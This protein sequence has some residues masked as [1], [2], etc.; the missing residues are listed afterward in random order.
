VP[1]V[2]PWKGL[3][4][5]ELLRALPKLGPMPI[6]GLVRRARRLADLSQRQMARIA[7]VSAATVGRIEA[8]DITPSVAVLQ[9]LLAAGGLELVAVDGQGR[10]VLPMGEIDDTRDGT[11]RRYP[12]H[13]DTIL[14]PKEGEWWADGY[15]LA[16]PPETFCRDRRRR[17]MARERSRQELQAARAARYRPLPQPPRVRVAEAYAFHEEDLVVEEWDED[18]EKWQREEAAADLG[19]EG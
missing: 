1:Q 11:G 13:L 3:G 5:E 16:R 7:H 18:F 9:R 10:R 8:G 14:D 12:S 19:G 2:G 15:G 4:D 6:A 17:E